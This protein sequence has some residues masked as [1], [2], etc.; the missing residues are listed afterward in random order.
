MSRHPGEIEDE[1]LFAI[2]LLPCS[3]GQQRH[4]DQLR[5]SSTPLR[6]RANSDFRD[7]KIP[8]NLS[9]IRFAQDCRT[10]PRDVLLDIGRVPGNET[11][12]RGIALAALF[13]QLIKC[14]SIL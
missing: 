8:R 1:L 3:R 14:L 5:V 6:H 11:G 10:A 13:D 4:L 12:N 7:V 9:A 2:G